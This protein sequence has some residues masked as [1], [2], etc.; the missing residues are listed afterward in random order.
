MAVLG[1]AT[2]SLLCTA[3]TLRPQR[4]GRRAQTGRPP[5]SHLLPAQLPP[6]AAH[7]CIATA[8]PAAGR[9][10]CWR[11]LGPNPPLTSLSS[12]NLTHLTRQPRAHQPGAVSAGI[13]C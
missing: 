2:R 11:R 6:G 13:Q 8:A 12:G 1:A 3:R 5:T 7:S 9:W 4:W 10:L